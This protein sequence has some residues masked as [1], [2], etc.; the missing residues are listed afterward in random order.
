MSV[1]RH[2]YEYEVFL[3]LIELINKYTQTHYIAALI[4]KYA[5]GAL[6]Y[7]V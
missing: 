2:A 5:R 1:L 7:H 3:D 4:H 6:E